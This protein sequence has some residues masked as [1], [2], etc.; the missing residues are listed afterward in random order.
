[1]LARPPAVPAPADTPG[2]PPGCSDLYVAMKDVGLAECGA[3]GWVQKQSTAIGY[4]EA[5]H[6]TLGWAGAAGAPEG[7]GAV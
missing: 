6:S 1:M 2:R 7:E 3:V 5:R 4:L